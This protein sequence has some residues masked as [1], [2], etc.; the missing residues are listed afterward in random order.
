MNLTELVK[1]AGVVGAGGAGFP[2]HVKLSAKAEFF[3]INAAECEPLIE[4]D[5]YL[6]R[7]FADE[8]VEGILVVAE[9]LGAKRKVIAL[10]AK[11]KA[12]IAA[13]RASIT[14]ACAEIEIFELKTFYPAGDEQVIVQQVCKKS[15]PERGIPIDVGVV[16]SN[17]GT[18]LNVTD[19]IKGIPVTDKYLSI[20]GEVETP[21]M[22]R[23]PVGT[24]I[25]ECIA[26]AKVKVPK[27]AIILGGPMMG[28]VIDN[29]KEIVTTVVTKTTGNIIILS[30][31]HNLIKWNR[32]SLER[33]AMQARSAC[34]QCRMCT[35]LCPRYLNGHRIYPHIVMR[36]IGRESLIT[37]EEE[38]KKAFGSAVNCCEC[39]VCEMFSCPMGLSPA[40]VNRFIKKRLRE[41]GIQIERNIK[42]EAREEVELHKTPTDRLIARLGLSSYDGQH[43]HECYK[44]DPGEVFL[45][46]SQHIGLPAVP[47]VKTGDTV[48][49]GDLV[50]V[51]NEKGLSANIHASI[52]GT[53]V[54]INEMG[55]RINRK[56]E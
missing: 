47:I 28:K 22:V 41:K 18:I 29:A 8:L 33:M 31:E 48:K 19:A 26:K 52:S 3:I 24:R 2:T 12:E 46:F 43:V 20:V 13:L 5:K 16:V 15:V 40:R 36:N 21:I 23:V 7:V 53:I 51:A 17:V 4:T 30:P 34:I 55:A 1:A 27:Y 32:V 6:C 54:E 38:Y 35:D 25:S 45:L 37:D 14:K 10:K 56:E 9:H 11:Y 42:P 39:G 44:V 49:K 50:A